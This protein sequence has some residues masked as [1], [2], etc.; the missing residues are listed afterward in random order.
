MEFII[1]SLFILLTRKEII[2]KRIAYYTK[3]QNIIIA[4]K[5]A[6]VGQTGGRMVADVIECLI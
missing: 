2:S 5:L 4:L 6:F 1:D 3:A